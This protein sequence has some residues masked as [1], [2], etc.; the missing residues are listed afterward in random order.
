MYKNWPAMP[1]VFSNLPSTI[2]EAAERLYLVLTLENLVAIKN[3]RKDN[4]PVLGFTLG[5]EIYEAIRVHNPIN[6]MTLNGRTVDY[7]Y[8]P[9]AIVEELWQQLQDRELAEFDATNH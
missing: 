2:E 3:M 8:A 4:L 9:S 6:F 5:L 7:L 1:T